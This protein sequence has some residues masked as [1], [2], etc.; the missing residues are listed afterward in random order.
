MPR[1]TAT[2]IRVGMLAAALLA[3]AACEHVGNVLENTGEALKRH[4]EGGD[5]SQAQGGTA[6]TPARTTP[7]A[8]GATQAQWEAVYAALKASRDECKAS[9]ETPDLNLIRH[10]VQLYRE[11]GDEPLPFEIATNDAFPS[12]EDRPVIARWASLRDECIRHIDAVQLVPQGANAVQTAVVQQLR[13]FGN[14][15]AGDVTDLVI[16]L[17]QQKLTYS[18]FGRKVNDLAGAQGA[19][20][21]AMQQANAGSNNAQQQLQD[22]QTAQQQFTD[23]LDAFSKYVRTVSARKPKTVRVSGAGN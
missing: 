9:M 6:Q 4:S 14:Q 21:L 16:S 22:L 2:L 23:M 11:P 15:A 3:L 17:Y 7:A 12:T 20:N 10:K 19:F 8:S 5:S 18:E 13:A 1:V